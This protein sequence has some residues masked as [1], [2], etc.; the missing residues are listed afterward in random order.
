MY[1]VK[2]KTTNNTWKEINRFNN[3]AE[4][5]EWLTAYIRI[6]KYCCSD[7]TISYKENTKKN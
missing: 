3:P 2:V 4:A 6:N 1:I 5:D 7:F